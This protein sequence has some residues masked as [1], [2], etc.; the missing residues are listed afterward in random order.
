M[1][2]FE[3]E[4]VAEARTGG[5]KY[6]CKNDSNFVLYLPQYISRDLNKMG[7]KKM[8]ICFSKEEEVP[9]SVK[10]EVKELEDEEVEDVESEE[11]T[12]VEE[13]A[14]EETVVEKKQTKMFLTEAHKQEH[15]DL[16]RFNEKTK[17]YNLIKTTI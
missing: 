2:I 1:N 6:V 10:E 4:L 15:P 5:D 17:R 9:V 8:F 3:F 16:Y 11:E 12:V 13:T 7:L 14:V